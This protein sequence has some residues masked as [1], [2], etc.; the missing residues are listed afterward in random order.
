MDPGVI[1]ALFDYG[2]IGLLL[3][4]LLWFARTLLI[5][6]QNRADAAANEVSRLNTM[7]QEKFLPAL[8]AA[9]QAISASQE[10]LQE[11]QL[12]AQIQAEARRASDYAK[13]N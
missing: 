3:I 13:P 11:M 12:K 5:R 8:V 1:K 2:G 7:I 10:I 9:T 6:E 4:I